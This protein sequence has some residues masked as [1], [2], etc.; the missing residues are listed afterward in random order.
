MT[1]TVNEDNENMLPEQCKGNIIIHC[2]YGYQE[3][4]NEPFFT[5]LWNYPQQKET[6]Q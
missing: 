5:Q 3:N 6:V 4:N 2:Q 1:C